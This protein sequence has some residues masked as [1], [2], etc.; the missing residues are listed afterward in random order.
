M[1]KYAS[2]RLIVYTSESMTTN[3]S[4]NHEVYG[5]KEFHDDRKYLNTYNIDILGSSKKVIF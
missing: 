4:S 2:K 1:L 3:A 5:T